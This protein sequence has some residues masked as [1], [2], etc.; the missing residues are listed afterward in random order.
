MEKLTLEQTIDVLK[1]VSLFEDIKSNAKGLQLVAERMVLKS[2]AKAEAITEQGKPG[3]EFFI[4][5][6]GQAGV[7]KQTPEG[8]PYKVFVLQD[9]NTPAFG[10]GGLIGGEARSATIICDEPVQC[11]IL[12]RVKFEQVCD[13]NPEVALP[14]LKKVAHALM[15]R[16]HQTTNDLMLLHKALMNEIRSN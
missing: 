12:S 13:L 11:L 8:D 4:M 16:L 2:F 9:K 7:Y 14:I 1:K 10:E 5:I 3:D 15:L 6:R